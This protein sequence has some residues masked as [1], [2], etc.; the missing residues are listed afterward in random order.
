[1]VL[2]MLALELVRRRFG[3]T[4]VSHRWWF[5]LATGLLAGFTTTVGNLA[6]SVMSIYLISKGLLKNRG[7]WGQVIGDTYTLKQSPFFALLCGTPDLCAFV[8]A[9]CTQIPRPQAG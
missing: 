9:T 2:G 4:E 8:P 7:E 6:G 5:V 1:M 3:W